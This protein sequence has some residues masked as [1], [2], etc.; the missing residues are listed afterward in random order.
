MDQWVDTDYKD[1]EGKLIRIGDFVEYKDEIYNV[2]ENPFN[3]RVVLD[4]DYGQCWLSD[5]H[6]DCKVI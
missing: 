5:V 2:Y 3:K 6:N 4:N 1:K